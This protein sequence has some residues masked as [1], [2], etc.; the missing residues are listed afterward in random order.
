MSIAFL[1]N[2]CNVGKK[3]DKVYV[4]TRTFIGKL[5]HINDNR[6]LVYEEDKKISYNIR[7]ENDIYNLPKNETDNKKYYI[8]VF[9]DTYSGYV[10]FEGEGLLGLLPKPRLTQENK[11]KM[12]ELVKKEILKRKFSVEVYELKKPK[13]CWLSSLFGD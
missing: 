11:E 13:F 9:K 12:K 3:Y 6:Y 5:E 1:C 10:G 4:L 2:I 7:I 8:R